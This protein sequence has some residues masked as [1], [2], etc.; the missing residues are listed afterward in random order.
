MP[1]TRTIRR[2]LINRRGYY[3][4]TCVARALGL[5]ID[6]IRRNIR[7]NETAEVVTRYGLCHGCLAEREVVGV[8]ISA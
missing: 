2:F 8:R 3:C 1:H 5:S 4:E 7:R 6:D